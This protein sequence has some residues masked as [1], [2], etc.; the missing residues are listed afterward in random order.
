MAQHLRLIYGEAWKEEVTLH[1][2]HLCY[3]LFRGIRHTLEDGADMIPEE[4]LQ[5]TDL[6]Y[7]LVWICEQPPANPDPDGT[8]V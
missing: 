4:V 5:A 3:Y 8:A 6:L 2:F 7:N 1:C